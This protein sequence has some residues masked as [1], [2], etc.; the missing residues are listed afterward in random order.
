MFTTLQILTTIVVAVA[1]SLALAH[2]LELPGKMR[3]TKDVYYA[4]QPM[5]HPGFTIGGISEPAGLLLTIV[6]LL[7]TPSQSPA[8][9]LAAAVLVGLI[10]MQAVYGLVTHA[11]N[12]FWL[13]ARNLAVPAPNSSPSERTS[14]RGRTKLAQLTGP[15]SAIAGSIRTWPE[16]RSHL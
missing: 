8:F 13:R 11:V 4:V 10:G 7:I 14:R 5:Y 6:L 9:W 12:N 1:M 3:L 2:A 15:S 16:P